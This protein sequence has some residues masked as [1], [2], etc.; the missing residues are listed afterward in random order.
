MS[1]AKVG[2]ST[3]VFDRFM[4]VNLSCLRPPVRNPRKQWS[5]QR[6]GTSI[7]KS[8]VRCLVILPCRTLLTVKCSV[9]S[10]LNLPSWDLLFQSTWKYLPQS[11]LY[12]LKYLP[13][14]EYR[15]FSAYRKAAT[16][17]GQALI[18]EKAAGTEKGS[19]DIMSI[20]GMV[21]PEVFLAVLS[22]TSLASLVQSNC[23]TDAGSKLSET[24]IL[25]EIACVVTSALRSI[26][27]LPY[28]STLLV[29]GH[30]TTAITLTWLL[31]ELS[32]RPEEQQQIR[33]EIKAARAQ[34]E[35]RGDHD[36]LPGDLSGMT[37][38]NAVIKVC[39]SFH[40]VHSR[41]H[42]LPGGT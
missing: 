17:T 14:K 4:F 20:L 38:M 23:L 5:W 28:S 40:L 9:D 16:R 24:E 22:L 26:Y 35:A 7:Q 6:V 2:F 42:R 34:A 12:C 1:W 33:D 3:I 19:K 41:L 18:N 13:Y 31:Y 30:D 21:T 39:P 8:V 36:L 11:I 27:W 25:S 15:R 37:F 10:L 32:K 29:A